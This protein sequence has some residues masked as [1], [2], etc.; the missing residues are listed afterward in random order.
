[1]KDEQLIEKIVSDIKVTCG[2]TIP[3]QKDQEDIIVFFRPCSTLEYINR[4]MTMIDGFLVLYANNSPSYWQIKSVNSK[5]EIC[6]EMPEVE[7]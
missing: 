7:G 5:I 2:E 6:G 4:V 3:M 1:M